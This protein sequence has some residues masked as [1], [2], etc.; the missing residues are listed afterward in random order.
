MFKS[1]GG[2][3]VFDTG[4]TLKHFSLVKHHF[5]FWIILKLNIKFS[6]NVQK[7]YLVL[8][9]N[10]QFYYFQ[11]IHKAMTKGGVDDKRSDSEPSEDED[12]NDEKKDD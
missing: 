8:E 6:T 2:Y 3:T 4:P 5:I 10:K 11:A 1:L 9:I 7:H 12:E